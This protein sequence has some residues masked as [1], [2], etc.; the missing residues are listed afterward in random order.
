MATYYVDQ[1]VGNN[2]NAGTSEGSGN[3]WA[4]I[5]KAADTVAA[6][7]KVWVKNVGG[8]YVENIT[9]ATAGT[10]G[11]EI[12]WEGYT[13]STGDNG[14]VTINPSSGVGVT[15]NAKDYQVWK[16]F[17]FTGGSVGYNGSTTSDRV[18]FFNC[19]F[20][21]NSGNGA[22]LGTYC[23]FYRCQFDNNSADGIDVTGSAGFYGC[24]AF[25]NSARQIETDDGVF[26]RCLVYGCASG[27]YGILTNDY[28][29]PAHS[30]FI[31]NTIDGENTTVVGIYTAGS[32]NLVAV[33]D[34]ILY[35]CGKGIDFDVTN[36]RIHNVLA[37]N[38]FN[39]NTTAR[40]GSVYSVDEVTTAPA[41]TD[42]ASDDYTLGGAS[43]A[44]DAGMQVGLYT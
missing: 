22:A 6:A 14:R 36:Q 3:A 8:D 27:Q 37:N 18:T 20:D 10:A 21:N 9:L 4:T 15:G 33:I 41:F 17:R 31:G 7:D 40:E 38:L 11:S 24:V 34:N 42:E 19:R 35:D 5:Q 39:S 44:I 1:A 12:E 28:T 25:A 23:A 43:P 2:A 29:D 32:I 30:V 16:N 13:S 26:Y